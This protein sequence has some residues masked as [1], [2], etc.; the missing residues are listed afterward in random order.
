MVRIS[1]DLPDELAEALTRAAAA[2]QST[3]DDVVRSALQDF[4][5]PEDGFAAFM[6]DRD[7]YEAW[8]AEGEADVAAGRI[9]SAEDVFAELDDIIAAARKRRGE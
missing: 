1:V 2:L 6:A 4:L 9:V 3:R 7:G 8:V 5:E